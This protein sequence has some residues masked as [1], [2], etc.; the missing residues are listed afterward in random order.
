MY[1]KYGLKTLCRTPLKTGLFIALL[2]IVTAL[3]GTGT[4]MWFTAEDSLNIADKAFS[5]IGTIE[6]RDPEQPSTDFH[7]FNYDFSSITESSYVQ[8]FD[9]RTYLAAMSQEVLVDMSL[10]SGLHTI[11]LV[12]E[13]SLLGE[14]GDERSI[15]ARIEKVLY[16]PDPAVEAGQVTTLI[17]SKEAIPSLEKGKKYVTFAIESHDI[18]GEKA[19]AVEHTWVTMAISP[20]GHLLT[21]ENVVMEVSGGNFYKEDGRVWDDLS[22]K[23][24]NT[25]HTLTLLLTNDHESIL[26]FHQHKTILTSGRPISEEDYLSGNQVCLISS[27]LAR[28]NGLKL[29]DSITIAYADASFMSFSNG[30]MTAMAIDH[31]EPREQQKFQIVGFYK[32]VGHLEDQYGLSPDTMIVPQSSISYWPKDYIT[33]D[34]QIS[35]RLYNGTVEKFLEDM[36]N[37]SLPGLKYT[38]YDQGYKEATGSLTAMKK[39]GL[40]MALIC[41]L[42]GFGVIVLFSQLFLAK[43]LPSVAIM[44][45][46]GTNRRNIL[47]YLLTAVLFVSLTGAG[48]GGFSG[49]WL[50]EQVLARAY[51]SNAERIAEASTFSGV[52]GSDPR[53]DFQYIVPHKLWTSIFMTV[54]ILLTTIVI[55]GFFVVTIIRAEPMKV[56]AQVKE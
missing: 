52:Y 51:T 28:L 30:A 22:I 37:K 12:I 44:Y 20:L 26:S 27:D 21:P 55:C 13:F 18:A 16:T 38:F 46:L 23:F 50:S 29:G 39:T 2:C 43:Q 31:R 24:R 49:Y 36:M 56:L 14:I 34:N 11:G 45:S 9:Q 17:L 53:S 33:R 54:L 4:N 35:L 25:R 3:L 5:T 19:Y 41:I 6:Y 42:T 15:Q 10:K 40:L 8:S 1:A 48:I 7:C 47:C 32:V